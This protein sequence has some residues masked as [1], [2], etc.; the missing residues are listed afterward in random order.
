[1]MKDYVWYSPEMDSFYVANK[2]KGFIFKNEEGP[3]L[4]LYTYS[5]YKVYEFYLIG[6]L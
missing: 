4:A 2:K 5:D 6:A 3:F 1:M